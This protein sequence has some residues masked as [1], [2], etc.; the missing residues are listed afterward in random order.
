MKPAIRNYVFFILIISVVSIISCKQ[1]QDYKKIIHDPALY[2]KAVH[3]INYVVIYDIFTPPVASR[4]FA[5]SNLAAYAIMSQGDSNLSPLQGK[6]KDL[7]SIPKP[8]P[9]EE[10]DYPFA[11][12][13]ALTHV[14]KELTFS[15]KTMQSLIDS[16]KTLA[17]NTN[18]SEALYN[19][20][21]AY[22][23]RVAS[24]I[25]S[26][27]KKDNYAKTRGSKFTVTG[28]EGHWSPT[29]PG[30]FDAVE[31]LWM[32]IRTLAIDSASM[33]A[34]SGPPPFS[35]EKG[36]VFYNAAKQDYDTVNT[37]DTTKKW[38]ANFWDCNS[39]KLFVNGHVMTTSKAMTPPGH[40]ME[41]AGQI[42]KSNK[43]DFSKTVLTYTSI[44]IGMFDGFISSWYNKYKWDLIRPETYINLY[45]DPNWRPY[46]QSPPFPEFNSAHSTISSAAATVLT[47]L[48][49]KNIAF[50]DSSERDWGWPDRSF[51]SLDEAAW[52]VSMSRFYGGIHYPFSVKDGYD[53]GKKIG[54][55]VTEKL[56]LK[57]ELP[58]IK[59]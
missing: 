35:K 56:F 54:D 7:D 28:L 19:G 49:G 22:G 26:W 11:S 38:I 43:A 21:I 27:S 50:I 51:K 16:I 47:N 2:S 36:S 20:S 57:N 9:G 3:E 33:F 30:Y 6:I 15:D 18:M 46:L 29:P 12:L 4:I 58:S 24:Y 25:M 53:T 42:A 48:Y 45:I 41:I 34:S 55:R 44:S 39:F 13:I 23:E 37:L 52:E 10:V 8:N 59:N 40:W 5:Y 31:P 32:T 14:G 17:K 1:R